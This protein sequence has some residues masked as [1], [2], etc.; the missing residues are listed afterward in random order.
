MVGSA[1]KKHGF[2][3]RSTAADEPNVIL[4]IDE[5]YFSTSDTITPLLAVG[6]RNDTLG[7][8]DD[9]LSQ[10]CSPSEALEHW[11]AGRIDEAVKRQRE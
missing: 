2:T 5:D 10:L 4:D 1:A 11:L 8:V 9:V 7:R 6:W 3:I